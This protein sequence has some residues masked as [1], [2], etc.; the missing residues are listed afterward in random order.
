MLRSIVIAAVVLVAAVL[1][2]AATRR[3]DFKVQRSIVVKAAP[4]RILPLITDFRRWPEWSPYE[5]LDP[6]MK[7]IHAGAPRGVGAVYE[8]EGNGKAGAGRM[9]IKEVRA[10]SR[11]TIQLDFTKP[12]EGRNVAE[13]ALEPRAG[14]TEVIWS[15]RGPSPY[16]MKLMGIFVNLDRMIGSD[17]ENG[18]AN[19]KAVAER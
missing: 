1:V 19:L 5:K 8:W 15:M 13:F 14:G 4:E 7:R 18:L 2:F 3:D 17:F 10:P 16:L 12:V 9:E 6:A 11:V